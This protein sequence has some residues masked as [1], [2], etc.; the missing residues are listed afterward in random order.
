[1]P[2]FCFSRRSPAR[3]LPAIL[4]ALVLAAA[5]GCTEMSWQRPDTDAS[6]AEADRAECQR[7]AL[8][9][10]KR[11]N[12]TPFL[13]PYFVTARDNRGRLRSIPVVP[14]QQFGPP[15]WWPNAPSLA[16][17]QQTLKYDLFRDCLEAKGYEL[18]PVENAPVEN[19]PVEHA[20]GDGASRPAATPALQPA[21]GQPPQAPSPSS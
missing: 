8:R 14:F 11:L 13:V 1:M 10:A 16:M 21:N 12:E 19:A 5:A 3:A 17:D 7:I 6:T 15:V 9:Q 4:A 18:L 2:E 20:P